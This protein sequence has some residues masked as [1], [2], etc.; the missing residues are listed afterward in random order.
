MQ[1]SITRI[2]SFIVTEGI[3]MLIYN[4]WSERETI[5]VFICRTD[6]ICVVRQLVTNKATVTI[7]AADDCTNTMSQKKYL[8][9]PRLPRGDACVSH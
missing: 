7:Q 1:H 6:I 4:H 9:V 5:S 2:I 3:S 8:R